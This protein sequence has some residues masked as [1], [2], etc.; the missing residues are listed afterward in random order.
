MTEGLPTRQ[1]LKLN[2]IYLL[3]GSQSELSEETTYSAPLRYV[4]N[5]QHYHW[6]AA[7]HLPSPEDS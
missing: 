2:S 1:E 7:A 3:S 4:L 6:Y 5:P